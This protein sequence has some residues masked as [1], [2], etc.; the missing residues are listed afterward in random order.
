VALPELV[1]TLCTFLVLAPL[2]L[3]PGLGAFLFRPMAMAVAFAMIAAY[4]LS[5]TFVP[6][7]SALWLKPHVHGHDEKKGP[8]GRAFERWERLI[9]RGIEYYVKGLDAVMSRPRTTV[10]FAF[11]MLAVTLV[12]LIPVIRREF[13]PEADAGAFEMAVRAPSG[14]RIEVTNQRIDEVEKYLRELIPEH[15]LELIVS[16]IGVTADW[17][18]AY[19]QNAGPMDAMVK[20]QLTEHRTH[21]AQEY[22][23]KVRAAVQ[24]EKEKKKD[25]RFQDLEF[26][27]DTGGLIRGA[28][29]EGKSTPINIRVTG[30]DLTKPAQIAA[31]IKSKVTQ[32]DGVVDARILQ[33]QNYPEFIVNVDRTKAADLGMT[34]E[35][36]MRN[37]VASLNSSITFNKKNFW[38]DPVSH[39][40]YFVG[41]AYPEKDITS[42]ETMLDIPITGAL[43][44]EPVPLRTLATITRTTVPTEITHNNLQPSIDL[45]MGVEGRDLGHVAD[46]IAKLLEEF[47]QKLPDGNWAPFDPS[48]TGAKRET[49]KGSKIVLSGEYARM[50]TTFRDLGIGMILAV[51]LMYFLMVALDKS[52]I[53]PLTV[54]LTVP[55]SMAG[56]FPMLYLTGTAINVQSIL[57]IIFIIGIKVA[58]TVLMTDF[59][60]EIRRHEGLT[61]T[62]AIR[63]AASVRVR[64]VTMTALAAFFAMIPGAM[65][66]ERGSE[67]NAPLARAILG[68]LL[69]GEPA[70]LFVLPCLYMLMVKDKPGQ[71]AQG[72]NTAENHE[73]NDY[74]DETDEGHDTF[75]HH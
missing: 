30:K 51:I 4:I 33:R 60:Q 40:Q 3:M 70:T 38:I 75:G 12:L 23:S 9:D 56:V 50:Q 42:L 21:S 41:V 65:A 6:S 8:I 44:A 34:Q 54:M 52:Y 47:G 36:V 63:K 66:L 71:P 61:P 73:D 59:A 2:A 5:R 74:D 22:A 57:G 48:G 62:Q 19:T 35:D 13:F 46:D 7:R 25:G 27:F 64:P 67:A 17:S 29:N 32:I 49:L 24:Q 10:A 45:T 26:S 20:V 43:K 14:T 69:A 1:S 16:E 37:V 31:M 55:I 28:L 15:D 72:H 58:N 11:T 53:V 39:N 18:A 68:G